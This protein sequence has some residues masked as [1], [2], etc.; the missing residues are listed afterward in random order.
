M[1][2]NYKKC[3]E[4][5]NSFCPRPFLHFHLDTKKQ[6]KLCCFTDNVIETIEGY[7][8]EKYKTIRNSMINNEK[9]DACKNCYDY[10]DN[11]QISPRQKSIKDMIIH[12]DLLQKQIYNHQQNIE[13]E[14]YWYDLRIS[15][16]CN[17]ACIMCGPK[18]SSTIAKNLNYENTHLSYEPDVFINPDAIKIYFA[19]GEPFLIKKFVT[20]LKTITNKN[21]EII[22]NTN[23]TVLTKTFLNELQKFSKV[24]ITVSVDGYKTI[25]EK[26]RKN[27]TWDTIEKNIDI[28]ISMGFRVDINT[29]VQ[30]ENIN[31]LC[32]L[33]D[34]ISTKDIKKWTLS[35]LFNSEEQSLQNSKVNKIHIE[36]LLSYDI[37]K[38]NIES[39]NLLKSIIREYT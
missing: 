25:N 19:G 12:D 29:V 5:G 9:I 30:K 1:T 15:N 36:K 18:N 11:K 24:S 21:C 16:N 31:F 22:V 35:K 34:Y 2:F 6:K 28:L 38:N 37:V 3:L 14:P 26:I 7:N 39:V 20:F 27:S 23:G 10:E 4:F 8:T 17:L 32:E 33:A 13:L